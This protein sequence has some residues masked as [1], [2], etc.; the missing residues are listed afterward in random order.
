M[1]G[2]S[3]C[4]RSLRTSQRAL[5]PD[6]SRGPEV[7]TLRSS[8][9]DLGLR[10]SRRE[11]SPRRRRGFGGRGR[12]FRGPPRRRRESRR[13]S[14]ARAA[15]ASPWRAGG[16]P[17]DGAELRRRVRWRPRERPMSAGRVAAA[18][19]PARRPKLRGRVVAVAS[20]PW[21]LTG[22]GT[23]SGKPGGRAFGRANV[24]VAGPGRAFV[25]S[26]RS[27]A[28]HFACGRSASPKYTS[29]PFRIA[30][31]S[32]W[33]LG[34]TLATGAASARGAAPSTARSA[35]TAAFADRFAGPRLPV[36]ADRRQAG[37]QHRRPQHQAVGGHRGVGAVRRPARRRA[38]PRSA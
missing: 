21:R 5:Q 32:P 23:P 11:R 18:L 20:S 9:L 16:G 34:Y 22:G 25:G 38:A 35:S 36:T 31:V 14:P 26:T 13:R 17:L 27:S 6:N 12:R 7:E 19:R 15:C 4:Q 37:R 2:S 1:Q 28:R 3:P 8:D 33:L 24:H 30:T 29:R 10:L